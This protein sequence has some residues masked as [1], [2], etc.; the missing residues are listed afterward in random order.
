MILAAVLRSQAVVLSPESLNELLWGHLDQLVWIGADP[1]QMLQGLALPEIDLEQGRVAFLGPFAQDHQARKDAVEMGDDLVLEHAFDLDLAQAHP[2]KLLQLEID[3]GSWF[4]GCTFPTPQQITDGATVN[5]I[6]FFTV[7]QLLVSV[8]LDRKAV[9]QC[10][11]LRLLQQMS[12]QV[13]EV[14]AGRLHADQDHLGLRFRFG[15]INRLTELI[16]A[17]LIEIDIEGRSD[18]LT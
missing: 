1:Q 6:R 4:V 16:E 10:H 11:W 7:H 9:D 13:L 8:L 3:T 12:G 5:R 14:V 17:A 15:L 2:V 18:D